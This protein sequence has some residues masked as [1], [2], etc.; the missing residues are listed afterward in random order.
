[1]V[2]NFLLI[3]SRVLQ[4]EGIFNTMLHL[5]TFLNQTAKQKM[6]LNLFSE[7]V[8]MLALHPRLNASKTI[9]KTL[10]PTTFRNMNEKIN[11][12]D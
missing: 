6:Q 4:R 11:I 1:M 5:H 10:L 3:G 8:Q 2:H 7:N 9:N 12:E